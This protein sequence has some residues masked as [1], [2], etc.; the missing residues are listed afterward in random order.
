MKKTIFTICSVLTVCIAIIM[1]CKKEDKDAIGVSYNTQPGYDT[2]NN[3][4]NTGG[5]TTTTGGT[6]TGASVT[7]GTFTV[8]GTTVTGITGN[9][10]TFV[11]YMVLGT[12]SNGSHTVLIEFSSTA[13]PASGSYTI[14]GATPAAGQCSFYYEN[15]SGRSSATSGI[16]TIST[17]SPNTATF[18]GISVSGAAGSHTISGTIYY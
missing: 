17:G 5:T 3:P 2:G 4:S 10:T 9:G 15:S 14:S 8:D 6:T 18:S 1:S 16:V 13:A 12:S 11:T 7:S